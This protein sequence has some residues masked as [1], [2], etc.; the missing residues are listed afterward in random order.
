MAVRVVVPT[1]NAV[2]RPLVVTVAADALDEVHAT[3]EVTSEV[4]PSENVAVAVNC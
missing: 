4:V 2:A 1:A 3:L